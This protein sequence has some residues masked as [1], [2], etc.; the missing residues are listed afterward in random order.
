M[1]HRGVL[2]GAAVGMATGAWVTIGSKVTAGNEYIFPLYKLSFMWYGTAT[3][4]VT[5]VTAI[6]FSEFFRIM[7]PEI[8]ERFIEPRLMFAWLRPKTNVYSVSTP[9]RV[10]MRTTQSIDSSIAVST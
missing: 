9:A 8:K 4:L 2:T 3:I 1:I 6:V 7:L 5:L 10:E